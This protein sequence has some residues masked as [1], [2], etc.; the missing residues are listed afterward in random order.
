MRPCYYRD[1]ADLG[2]RAATYLAIPLLASGRAAIVAA[3][4]HRDEILA[5]LTARGL[6]VAS[7]RATHRL[8]LVDVAVAGDVATLRRLVLAPLGSGPGLRIYGELA[9]ALTQELW[10]Q[11]LEGHDAE[12]LCGASQPA[13]DP[14]DLAAALAAEV[15]DRREL[16]QGLRRMHGELLQARRLEAAAVLAGG[17]AHHYNNLMCVIEGYAH[18]LQESLATQPELQAQALEICAAVERVNG[19]TRHMTYFSSPQRN[20]AGQVEPDAALASLWPLARHRVPVAIEMELYPGAAG[21]CVALGPAELE[22]VMQALIANAHQAMPDGGRLTVRTR[23]VGPA[24]SPVATRST[25]GKAVVLEVADTGVGMAADVRARAFEPFFTSQG[26]ASASGLGLSSV[27][28]LVTAAGGR[29]LLDSTPGRGTRVQI[30]L[31]VI[32]ALTRPL[33]LPAPAK[34]AAKVVL[35]VEDEEAVRRM[36]TAAL[37]KQG[38]RVLEAAGGNQAIQL[39]ELFTER[40]D[41]V[42]ADVLMPD[43]DG[44]SLVR[45]ARAR[46]GN[47]PALFMSGRHEAQ[48][49]PV[50][51]PLINKPFTT[52]QLLRAVED[53][54]ARTG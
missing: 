34:V 52:R 37:R 51:G 49:E 23:L 18:Q 12:L 14:V 10:E 21:Q 2:E 8:V 13:T 7:L 20:Q 17:I 39:L 22:L 32:S 3:P 35:V 48:T 15:A 36:V 11:A 38:Y 4:A 42:L 26:L 41:L 44:P 27:H 1:A 25:F 54:L 6:D 40:V 16:E 24:D 5:Q 45:R 46:H 28:G 19:L 9:G 43:M 50:D 33:R 53:E 31:P 29:V 30:D 47:V